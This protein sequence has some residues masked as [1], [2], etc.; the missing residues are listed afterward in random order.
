MSSLDTINVIISEEVPVLRAQMMLEFPSQFY[1]VLYAFLIVIKI[2][3]STYEVI[4]HLFFSIFF[5]P[6]FILKIF[7]YNIF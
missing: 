3:F 4:P 5:F 6:I 1:L 2:Q 7:I